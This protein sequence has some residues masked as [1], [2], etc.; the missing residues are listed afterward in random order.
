MSRQNK[1]K[2]KA[3]IAAQ[4]TAIHKTGNKGPNGT[5]PKHSKVRSWCKMGRKSTSQMNQSSHCYNKI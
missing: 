4:F 3:V 1:A 2:K 5:S